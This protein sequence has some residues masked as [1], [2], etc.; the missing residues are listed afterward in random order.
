M[1]LGIKKKYRV[2]AWYQDQLLNHPF[3]TAYKK[4]KCYLSSSYHVIWNNDFNFFIDD[5][6]PQKSKSLT[7]P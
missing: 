4:N 5:F 1:G 7:A 6:S 3:I 2:A